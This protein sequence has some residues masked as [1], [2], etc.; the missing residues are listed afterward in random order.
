MFEFPFPAPEDLSTLT[1]DDLV[2][3]LGEVRTFAASFSD[4]PASTET[5]TA[6]QASRDL[7]RS[8]TEQRNIRTEAASLSADIDAD[9]RVPEVVPAQLPAEPVVEPTPVDPE[10]VTAA[11]AGR[12]PSVRSIA[13]MRP[14]A[15]AQ[16]PPDVDVSGYASMHAAMDVPGLFSTGQ[17][18]D[19]F[20][21]AS[22][23]LSAMVDRYASSR[24]ARPVSAEGGG[25]SMEMRS[26]TR[27]G[28]VQ[29]RRS[30]PDDLRVDDGGNGMMVAEFAASERRLPGGSL[31]QSVRQD[32]AG[33]RSLTAAAGWCAPSEVIYNLCELET[34][35][36]LLAVPEIQASRGGFQIP[37]NGGPD[38]STIWSG[39]GNAGTTHLSEANVVSDT[40]KHC[41]VIP[42]PE[43]H[44][45][46]LGVD[47]YCLTGSL[48]Q[49]RGYPEI[50]S[51]FARGAMVAL[52]HKIN[53]GVIAA[54][55][56]ASGAATVIPSD[57]SGDDAISGVLS[58]VDLAIQDAK[59]RNRM[60][61]SATL[62]VVLPMWVLTQLRAAGSRRRSANDAVMIGLTDAQI[63]EWFA[64]RGAIPRFVYDW[65]DAF[66]GLA[67]GPGGAVPLWGLPLTVQ[68]LVYPTGTWVK[69]VQPV[70]SLDTVYDSTKLMTNE[71]TAVFAEDGWAMLQMTPTT[72]LYTAQVDPSGV[73]G[74]CP[75]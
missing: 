8:V 36:G 30:F 16:L 7:A 74:C 52:A 51:R 19:R 6:L 53:M 20:V 42:C 39:I 46:R 70:V 48:L 65:Q 50:V 64:L 10:P 12:A 9:T 59:Y 25:A 54:I 13:A 55:V 1:D 58:A 73:T 67:T 68:F 31:L 28:A 18:L 34:V 63:V 22:A 43:F 21:D 44:D 69:A 71:Y 29:F 15:V 61:A 17:R 32:V 23:V 24:T 57:F 33:G 66:S 72:R 2:A 26:F 4:K 60:G 45:V 62:E 75:S 41:M 27:H 14:G 38:F 3:L 35:D 5:I 47:Y 56:A 37:I 40:S 11:S 49:R